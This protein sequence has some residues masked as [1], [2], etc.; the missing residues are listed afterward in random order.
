MR[1]GAAEELGTGVH[2]PALSGAN[3]GV[4]LGHG[5]PITRQVDVIAGPHVLI[6]AHRA[7]ALLLGPLRVGGI[8]VTAGKDVRRFRATRVVRAVK[9]CGNLGRNRVNLP[10]RNLV[11]GELGADHRRIRRALRLVG[12]I[13]RIGNRGRWIVDGERPRAEVSAEFRGGWHPV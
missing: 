2:L 11:A 6:E 1:P 9:E 13:G 8:V 10:A 5:S 12:V 3:A 7:D 4:G